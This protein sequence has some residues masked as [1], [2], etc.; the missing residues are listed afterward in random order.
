MLGN[1]FSKNK[2]NESSSIPDLS[3][4]PGY[5]NLNFEKCDLIEIPR[6]WR[7]C[8][9]CAKYH[10]RIYSISGKDVRFPKLPDYIINHK[11]TEHGCN[12]QFYP[13]HE[14]VSIMRGLGEKNP[15]EYSNRPFLDDRT[16][17]ERATYEN[18]KAK[19]DLDS[20]NRIEYTW[21]C[22]NLPA[23]APKSLS[24]YVRMKNLNSK[25]YIKLMDIARD[26]GFKD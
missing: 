17:E 4:I 13:Y 5:E 20:K 2:H 9:E 19:I 26:N 1:W 15:I 21:I 3:W 12:F 25:N 11:Y 18:Y 24:S 23:I 14:G 10:D 22:K 7:I 6:S 16:E 8:A